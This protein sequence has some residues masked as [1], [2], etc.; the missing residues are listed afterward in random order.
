MSVETGKVKSIKTGRS[1]AADALFGRRGDSRAPLAALLMTAGAATIMG[2]PIVYILI[3]AARGGDERWLRLLNTRLPA[4]IW[5]TGILTVT[6]TAAS[7]I[8]GALLAFLVTRTDLPARRWFRWMLAAPLAI[9]PYVGALCFIIIFGPSGWFKELIGAT[10]FSVYDSLFSATLV[11]T[12]FCYPYV[13]LIVMSSLQRMSHSYEETALSCGLSYPKVMLKVVF[14]ML[15]PAIGA[16]ALLAALYVLSDFGAVAMLRYETFVRAIYYQIEGRFDRSGAAILSAILIVITVAL[17]RLE[18]RGR[19]KRIYSS[20]AAERCNR[21]AIPLGR[22]KLPATLLVSLVFAFSVL[23]PVS[24]LV[25]WSWQGFGAGALSA[26]F[27]GYI[28]NSL[29]TAGVVALCCM[30]F[31]LPIVYLKSRYPSVLSRFASEIAFA[32]YALPGVIIALGVIFFFHRFLPFL[33]PTLAMVAFAHFMRFLP[34]GLG[35]GEASMA[36]ISPAVDEAARS[37]GDTPFQAI[38]RVILP[39]MM[40]GTLAGGALIFVS[41]LKELPATL[42]LRPPGFDTLS[43]RVWIEASEGFYHMAAP[44]ALLIIIFAALPMKLMLDRYR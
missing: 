24:V 4:L 17:L 3:Y 34:Q 30:L 7:S 28:L 41:S 38:Y 9:P 27:L 40:P 31:T 20:T 39:L 29:L 16:G 19:S 12:A 37:L 1:S 35:A 22:W 44:A 21:D 11:L 5:N 8:L 15:R 25:Y 42:L 23:L 13:Y 36:R 26:R 6:V 32:G 33:Y 2:I 10:P 43:V 14:P 18:R